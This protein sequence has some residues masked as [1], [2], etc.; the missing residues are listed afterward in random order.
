MRFFKQ[1]FCSFSISCCFRWHYGHYFIKTAGDYT[2]TFEA[3]R[4]SGQY[5][6]I[7]IDD[8][9]LQ[10]IFRKN[11]VPVLYFVMYSK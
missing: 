2:I 6:D 7:A 9:T 10:V 3:F 11:V 5:S 1:K 8:I 4:G